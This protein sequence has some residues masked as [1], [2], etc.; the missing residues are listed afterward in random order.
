MI[1]KSYYKI[2]RQTW[3]L[4]QYIF[5]SMNQ[6]LFHLYR[7]LQVHVAFRLVSVV[8]CLSAPCLCHSSPFLT[9]QYAPEDA[10]MHAHGPVHAHDPTGT[11]LTQPKEWVC[12]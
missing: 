5:S 3:N 8:I 10:L 6:L 7:C 2:K 12:I 4:V 11:L 1:N 9:P